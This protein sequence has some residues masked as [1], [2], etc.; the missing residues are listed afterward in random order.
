MADKPRIV[1]AVGQAV[2]SKLGKDIEKA[3]AEA[4]RKAYAEGI[5]DPDK[6]RELQLAARERV[7]K[8]E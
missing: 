7:K 2:G 1:E 4:V 6:I 3:M 8:G 5:T